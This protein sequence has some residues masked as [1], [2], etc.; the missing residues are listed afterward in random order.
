[1]S[2]NLDIKPKLWEFFILVMSSLQNWQLCRSIEGLLNSDPDPDLPENPDSIYN[3]LA[4]YID[5][6]EDLPD[7]HVNPFYEY[8]KLEQFDEERINLIIREA[9]THQSMV[10]AVRKNYNESGQFYAVVSSRHVKPKK[11]NCVLEC[12]KPKVIYEERNQLTLQKI[13]VG[14]NSTMIHTGLF[15]FQTTFH[16]L[17]ILHPSGSTSHWQ[18][19]VVDLSRTRGQNSKVNLMIDKLPDGDYIIGMRAKKGQNV[20]DFS[21]FKTKDPSSTCPT[22]ANYVY[23]GTAKKCQEITTTKRGQRDVVKRFQFPA[24]GWYQIVCSGTNFSLHILRPT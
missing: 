5:E 11:Q 1:M 4:E 19:K 3:A 13:E 12:I 16:G 15:H 22:S 7:W 6:R 9:I 8:V 17:I 14:Q 24:Y 21:V 23:D 20:G 2:L 10:I 18:D